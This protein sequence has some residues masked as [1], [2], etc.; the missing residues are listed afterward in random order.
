MQAKN[1][2]GSG[3]RTSS[4]RL[5]ENVWRASRGMGPAPAARCSTMDGSRP[6]SARSTTSRRA[7]TRGLVGLG[8]SPGGLDDPGPQL[9]G[10][11]DLDVTAQA[12]DRAARL[13]EILV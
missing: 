7:E 5:G 3:V 11:E 12:E 10:R 9:L 8:D 1:S 6:D 13:V 4:Q 2:A